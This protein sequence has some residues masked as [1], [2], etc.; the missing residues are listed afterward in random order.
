MNTFK[1]GEQQF[2]H[3]IGD[4]QC[5]GCRWDVPTPCE[6]GGLIHIEATPMHPYV[7][8]FRCDRCVG[9]RHKWHKRKKGLDGG[10]FPT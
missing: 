1:F 10:E 7:L 3:T 4:R 6:C 9:M 8:K 2:A 5:K